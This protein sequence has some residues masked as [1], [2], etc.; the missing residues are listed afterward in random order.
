MA[1]RLDIA[2]PSPEIEN[3]IKQNYLYKD[4]S[5]DL[6][7][8]FT[9]G[10]ELNKTLEKTDLYP[11]YDIQSV[12]NSLKNVFTTSPGE[13]ILNPTFGLDL[14]SYL[15]EPVTE[16]RGYFIG[17]EILQGLPEQEPRV[18]V[19]KVEVIVD[20]EE[21]QYEINLTIGIPSL[22]VYDLSLA[23]ILNNEGYTFV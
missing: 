9:E 2:R 5:L 22:N 10:R 16:T 21:Q 12:I 14:R 23:G 17:E 18:E 13:K 3:S 1:I 19:R 15:F 4:I 11:I 7:L 20:P 6:Q 8:G